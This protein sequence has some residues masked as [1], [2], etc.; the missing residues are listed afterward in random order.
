MGPLLRSL[1][2]PQSFFPP[3]S[4][5]LCPLP[6]Q[7]QP[8]PAA[9]APLAPQAPPAG[10]QRAPCGCW[11]DP[12]VFHIQW[13]IP[14]GHQGTAVAPAPLVLPT[15]IPGYQHIQGQWAPVNIT[16]MAT[17]A[18]TPGG[19]NIPRRS[20]NIP[21]SSSAALQKKDQEDRGAELQV[22]EEV[23]LE[24][25]HRLFSVSLDAM[26]V[27]KD[28]CSSNPTAPDPAGT[29]A[30]GSAVATTLVVSPTTFHSHQ[31]SEGLSVEM[32]N[33][34]AAPPW[35]HPQAT[36]TPWAPMSPPAPLLA[37]PWRS[38]GT[39]EPAWAFLMRS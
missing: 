22:S 15:S 39:W 19:R 21:T 2:S 10:L 36:T 17:V 23:L 13:S 34:S 4:A 24:E 9:W 25:A 6:G 16:S 12:R 37:P 5:P 33:S 1:S 14:Y 20:S 3:G 31:D 28:G 7:E 32:V 8:F 30:E 29:S 26:R 11:F 38:L 35:G 18:G 27:T